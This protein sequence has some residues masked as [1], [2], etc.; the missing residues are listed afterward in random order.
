[1]ADF[2]PVIEEIARDILSYSVPTP[3]DPEEE[4]AYQESVI[5]EGFWFSALRDVPAGEEPQV[6]DGEPVS[7]ENWVY[8]M[9]WVTAQSI[10]LG[11]VANK[12][13]QQMVDSGPI[14]DALTDL[15]IDTGHGV[16][17]TPQSL[18]D[19]EK[20]IARTNIGVASNSPTVLEFGSVA[21]VEAYDIPADIVSVN[22]TGYYESGDGGNALYKRVDTEPSHDGKIQSADG[23][24]WEITGNKLDVRAFGA[25]G[26]GVADD[27]LPIKA[28][29]D[30]INSIGGG[31][32]YAPSLY[33]V[34]QQLRIYGNTTLDLCG[35]G[36]IRRD[37]NTSP[38]GAGLM[39]I[40]GFEQSAITIRNGTLDGN[41]EVF[42]DGHNIFGGVRTSNILIENVTFLSVVDAHAIDLGDTQKVKIS[43]CK[44]LGFANKAGNRGYSEAI[45]LDAGPE[46]HPS[47]NED[48]IVEGCYFGPNPLLTDPDFG[49][50]GTGVGNHSTANPDYVGCWRV[51]IAQNTFDGCGYAGVRLLQWD[52]TAIIGNTFKNCSVPIMFDNAAS[53]GNRRIVI[54]ANTLDGDGSSQNA[55]YIYDRNAVGVATVQ[56]VVSANAFTKSGT[57]LR[58]VSAKNIVFE[59]N[60]ISDC[61][62]L[63]NLSAG[64]VVSVT[65]N[66]AEKLSGTAL[67]VS[68]AGV[69]LNAT[70][71]VISDVTGRAVHINGAWRTVNISVN[72]FEDIAGTN[73]IGVDSA[74]GEVNV[75]C[76]VMRVGALA[77]TPTGPSISISGSVINPQVVDNLLGAGM[78]QVSVAAASGDG[79]YRGSGAGT[80]E[81][82]VTAPIG[83]EWN[84]RTNGVKYMKKSGTGNTGWKL[85]T[86][87][88]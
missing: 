50:W 6:I 34:T 24:W 36:H 69:Q 38:Y 88:A 62:G 17:F 5:F 76:N 40:Q 43:N 87:A 27:F 56:V 37:F 33:S 31:T 39:G 29:F 7:N 78:P 8:L 25:V 81:S 19:D 30:Y 53:R 57:C 12:S 20:L 64:G 47:L 44:F 80:P 73:V 59:G 65:G 72:T 82:V 35:T 52:D 86:Q 10:G 3:Y 41:G 79:F 11:N 28:T 23:A 75:A 71:N 84:D 55:I 70:G 61:V 63:L 85:V 26:D 49:S 48:F 42:T 21:E 15:Q 67:Y 16:R 45:Q 32:I 2:R 68:G 77:K 46:N 18:T 13:E 66:T 51:R 1:M 60:S 83:S 4:Y 54:T 14:H 22:V 9:E 74:A 58:A